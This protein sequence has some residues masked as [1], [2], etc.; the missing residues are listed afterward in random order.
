MKTPPSQPQL[1][2]SGLCR[3]AAKKRRSNEALWPVTLLIVTYDEGTSDLG[4]GGSGGGH[5]FAVEV[6]PGVPNGA[7]VT[8]PMNHY[9]LFGGIEQRFHLARLGGAAGVTP[10]P[11]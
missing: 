5:V 8:K 10:L 4:V 7:E 2:P 6:G 3:T 11:I 1:I 9:S